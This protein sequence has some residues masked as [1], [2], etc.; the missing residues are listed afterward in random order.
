[1]RL[2]KFEKSFNK[3]K[4]IAATISAAATAGLILTAII[5]KLKK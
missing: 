2:K 4:G 5:R 1:M 3:I